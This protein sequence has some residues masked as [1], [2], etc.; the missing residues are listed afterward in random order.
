MAINVQEVF[1][2]VQKSKKNNTSKFLKTMKSYFFHV[3]FFGCVIENLD[4]I[5][6]FVYFVISTK[7][8]SH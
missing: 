1:H 7:E 8:K 5:K 6:I 3:I 4:I 2:I